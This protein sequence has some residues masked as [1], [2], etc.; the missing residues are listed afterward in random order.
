MILLP[1]GHFYLM[2]TLDGIFDMNQAYK[3]DANGD[4]IGIKPLS[5]SQDIKPKCCP[6][7]RTIVHSIGRYGRLVNF[8]RL[9]FL[10]R[11]HLISVEMSLKACAYKLSQADTKKEKLVKITE[12]LEDVMKEIRSGP[13]QKVFMACGGNNQ[14]EVPP[15]PNRPITRTLQLLAMSYS[16]RVEISNDDN[17]SKA[18]EKFKTVVNICDETQTHRLGAETRVSFSKLLLQWNDADKVRDEICS[19]LDPV[20]THNIMSKFT[21]ICDEAKAIKE[22]ASTSV[23]KATIQAMNI[24][25]GYDYGG[26]WSSHW[27]ECPN[28]HPYFIGNCGQAMETSRCIECGEIVGGSGHRLV[29]SNS[30]SHTVS[31]ILHGS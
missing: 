5:M 2:S 8:L 20:L 23:L 12:K 27:Y 18:I 11:K 1:C 26:S 28:G 22:Q 10:E 3:I 14:V 4:F 29:G 30:Q 24:V 15:P 31:S 25:D 6:D 19:I 7:C 16:R 21:D 13:T 17:Y 9:R